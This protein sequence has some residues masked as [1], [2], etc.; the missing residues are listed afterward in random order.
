MVNALAAT[1]RRWVCALD[2]PL[3]FVN[4][5]PSRCRC[6][7][8]RRSEHDA[9]YKKYNFMRRARGRFFLLQPL[10]SCVRAESGNWQPGAGDRRSEP[11]ASA[12]I[13]SSLRR[14]QATSAGLRCGVPGTERNAKR[15]ARERNSARRVEFPCALRGGK[16]NEEARKATD[17]LLV[18]AQRSESGTRTIRPLCIFGVEEICA[19]G[20]LSTYF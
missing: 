13:S 20:R 16:Q 4:Y 3:K 19:A 12:S 2:S 5:L 17:T 7:S 9:L 1:W 8:Q 10:W 14:R 18:D 11:V 6:N 15:D